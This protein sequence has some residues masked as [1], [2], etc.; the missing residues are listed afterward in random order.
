MSKS[1]TERYQT[2]SLHWSGSYCTG[3]NSNDFYLQAAVSRAI[4]RGAPVSYRQAQ[5][6]VFDLIAEMMDI[7]NKHKF[8]DRIR[9]AL[10]APKDPSEMSPEEQQAAQAQA[11]Q[12][13]QQ[14]M[15]MREVMAKI[16]K[17]EADVQ[18]QQAKAAQPH[19]GTG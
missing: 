9:Q 16:G 5:A 12:Q 4:D 7:P 2:T 8:I 3:A 11:Q 10:N 17:L 13:Q 6:A 19:A 1:K 14:E 15:A 18:V